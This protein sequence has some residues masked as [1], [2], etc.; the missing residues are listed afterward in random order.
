MALWISMSH[1]QNF[2]IWSVTRQLQLSPH[3]RKSREICSASL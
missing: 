2:K 1:N 3:F